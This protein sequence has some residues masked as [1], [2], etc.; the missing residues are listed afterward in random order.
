MAE[1]GMSEYEIVWSGRGPIPG[2]N[3][4]G[5]K[6]RS[7]A[8]LDDAPGAEGWPTQEE[9]AR[10]TPP[11]DHQPKRLTMRGRP[12]QP[13]RN[14][15]N[16]C[17]C[18]RWKHATVAICKGCRLGTPIKVKRPPTTHC[19]D[20]SGELKGH[21]RKRQLRRCSGCRKRTAYERQAA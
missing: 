10:Y 12:L 4:E 17:K 21:E 14:R 11:S 5:W 16:A 13:G 18:G 8:L 20:C 9:L 15:T 7:N 1:D 2:I 6:Y 19:V 3:G